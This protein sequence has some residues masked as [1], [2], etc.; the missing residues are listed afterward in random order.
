MKEEVGFVW[1]GKQGL[2]VKT[3]YKDYR[4]DIERG[5]QQLQHPLDRESSSL[6]CKYL[7]RRMERS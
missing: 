4:S 6:R 5:E 7:M 3:K 2:Y 1:N